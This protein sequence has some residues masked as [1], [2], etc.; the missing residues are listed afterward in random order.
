ML[1]DEWDLADEARRIGTRP[2]TIGELFAVERPSLKPL[3]V[4]TFETGR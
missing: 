1:I 3:P 4:E 2:R